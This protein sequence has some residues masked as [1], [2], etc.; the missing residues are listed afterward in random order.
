MKEIT[1]LQTELNKFPFIQG[2]I[3]V[4]ENNNIKRL[5]QVSIG[6]YLGISRYYVSNLIR[7]INADPKLRKI[8]YKT[9]KKGSNAR[10]YYNIKS[11]YRIS[12]EIHPKGNRLKEKDL[13]N[14]TTLIKTAVDN[15]LEFNGKPIRTVIKD[16]KQYYNIYDIL[17]HGARYKNPHQDLKKINK[18]IEEHTQLLPNWSKYAFQSS[19]NEKEY[20]Q[21][22]A[23]YK[24][25]IF[26]LEHVHKPETVPLKLFLAK[27]ADDKRKAD[28][29]SFSECLPTSKSKNHE[30]RIEEYKEKGWSP[31]K[32]EKRSLSILATLQRNKYLQEME[33][34]NPKLCSAIADK[35]NL[36]IIGCES[37]DFK[38]DN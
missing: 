3:I 28:I 17:K 24:Q 25:I 26:I 2:K 31:K 6:E 19:E 5:D 13:N 38:M 29:V 30:R 9:F 21:P 16:G 33:L 7:K 34:V 15:F 36:I 27:L 11:V 8:G 14:Q 22:A 10:K 35:F 32:I 1:K 12:K 37:K 20:V 4:D 23:T 18:L